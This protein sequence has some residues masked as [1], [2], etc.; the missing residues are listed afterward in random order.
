MLLKVQGYGRWNGVN[1]PAYNARNQRDTTLA[2]PAKSEATAAVALL[3]DA[4]ELEY[5]RLNQIEGRTRSKIARELGWP[6]ARVDRVRRRLNLHLAKLRAESPGICFESVKRPLPECASRDTEVEQA[7]TFLRKRE[8][9]FRATTPCRIY[10]FSRGN[11]LNPFYLEHLSHGLST[12]SLCHSNERYLPNY[13]IVEAPA[14]LPRK[15]IL[16]NTIDLQAALKAETAK[17]NR[18][19]ERAH[20]LHVAYDEA[21]RDLRIACTELEGEMTAAALE[22]RP[23][24]TESLEKKVTKLEA[25]VDLKRAELAGTENALQQQNAKVTAVEAEITLRRNERF[26]TESRPRREEMRHL[27]ERLAD[28]AT[29]HFA[30]VYESG[31]SQDWELALGS[32]YPRTDPT[33]YWHNGYRTAGFAVIN[34]AAALKREEWQKLS[35]RSEVA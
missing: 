16:M 15:G 20:A 22:E 32:V 21:S 5:F 23:S 2:Y 30:H 29:E 33:D 19:S 14:T 24:R 1:V 4:E 17:R 3:L 25:S 7:I 18:I 13:R 6:M 10:S 12:W 9:R 35:I 28:L 11:S 31:V 27:V 34:A 26:L 8:G